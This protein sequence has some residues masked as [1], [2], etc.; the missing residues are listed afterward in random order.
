M[1]AGGVPDDVLFVLYNLRYIRFV[2]PP[3]GQYRVWSVGHCFVI[4]M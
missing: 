2:C 4:V 3:S 1:P